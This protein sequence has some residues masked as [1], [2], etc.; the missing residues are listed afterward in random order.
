MIRTNG[1]RARGSN[2]YP[3]A[4]ARHS[5]FAIPIGGFHHF[6][7]GFWVFHRLFYSVFPGLCIGHDRASFDP[8]KPNFS[9]RDRIDAPRCID[10]ACAV[11]AEYFRGALHW[12]RRG[13]T[14]GRSRE[15]NIS[16]NKFGEK[17]GK[18][19]K[20]FKKVKIAKN[21]WCLPVDCEATFGCCARVGPAGIVREFWPKTLQQHPQVA[22]QSTGN[23][24]RMYIWLKYIYSVISVIVDSLPA[25]TKM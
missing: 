20:K 21:R 1:T 23:S 17:Q 14:P 15:N 16:M 12:F 3:A 11:P 25:N 6:C 18:K 5:K 19:R 2:L 4:A 8:T 10:P 7:L 24:S 13:E 22:S 9:N